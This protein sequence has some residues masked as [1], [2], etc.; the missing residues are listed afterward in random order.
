M[1]YEGYSISVH[2]VCSAIKAAQRNG[3]DEHALLEEAG[4]GQRLLDNPQMRLTSLQFSR[5]MLAL[6]RVGDDEFMGLAPYRSRHGVFALMARQVI[7]CRRLASVYYRMAR[8]YNLTNDSLRLELVADGE[9]VAF[10][11]HLADPERDPEHLL[12]EVFMLLW[13]RFS[14]WLVGQRIGLREVHF[15]YPQPTNHA[16]YGLMFP[17]PAR[18][19]MPDCRLVIEAQCM[20]MPVVQTAA[21]LR[22]HL[23]RAPLE[24]FTRPS[25]QAACTRSVSDLFQQ[26]GAFRDL[27]IEAAADALHITERTLRRRLALE[28]TRFQ[29]LKDGLRRDLAIH[30]LSQ[31]GLPISEIAQRLGFSEPSAFTRAFRQWTGGSPRSYRDAA[32]A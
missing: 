20:G 11:M 13:H 2:F 27:S 10:V 25:Y 17:C 26:G 19:S 23:Q 24:W 5:L 1:S 32:L 16:E 9:Q 7:G 8:F 12:R 14:S 21:T 15:D 3:L 22:E 18:F 31:A 4:I 29:T 6:W 30:Y 28:G